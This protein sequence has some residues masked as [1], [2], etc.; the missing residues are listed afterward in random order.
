MKKRFL[1]ALAV[2]FPL[3]G[4]TPNTIPSTIVAPNTIVED[5]ADLVTPTGRIYGTLELPTAATP[6][7]VVLIIAGSGP[8]DRN[9][10]TPVL[11]GSNNSLKMLADE[12]AEHG[13]ASLRYDKRGIAA[14]RAAMT[15]EADI[16]FTHY[17]D[18]AR[19]WVKQLRADPRFSTITV[20]GHSEGS[21][22]GMIAAREGGADGFISLEG[23]GRNAKGIIAAQLAAQLPPDVVNQAKDMMTKIEAGQKVDSV[24]PFLAALFRPSV[25]P[26]LVSWFKLTPSEEIA[27][28]TIPVLII[29]GTTDIQT[30][31]EDARRLVDALP[32]ANLSLVAGMN[33]VLKNA[34]ADRAQQMPTYTDPAIPIVPRLITLVVGFVKGVKKTSK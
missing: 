10:N 18:D 28:L 25:Q 30:S 34:P 31:V 11:P 20:V 22:V 24:P 29:Q 5:S 23:A 12:L 15:S 14:S 4:A 32:S 6:V 2:L 19:D 26:Y 1:V 16:R 33:H 21:L 7:P 13:I 3:A 17:V 8:T 27:K 9:G